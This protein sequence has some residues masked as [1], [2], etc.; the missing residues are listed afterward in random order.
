VARYK[1]IPTKI[2]IFL[3]NNVKLSKK[4]IK[5]IISAQCW[6][7]TLV[8][9]ATYLGGRDQEDHTSNQVQANSLQDP[10]LKTNF[11]KKRAGRV[12]QSE[13]PEFKS[14]Y[15]EWGREER[16]GMEVRVEKWPKK[17]MHI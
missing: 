15:R 8:I 10:I 17:C 1:K 5:N 13:G 9:L 12:A 7:L 16:V 4:E 14:Q 3:H 2:V 11:T 6:W